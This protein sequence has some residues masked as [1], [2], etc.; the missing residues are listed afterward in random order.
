MIVRTTG[1]IRD[2]VDLKIRIMLEDLGIDNSNGTTLAQS[3]I[4]KLAKSVYGD[5]KPYF[6]IEGVIWINTS[7]INGLLNE[8]AI[9]NDSNLPKLCSIMV[10]EMLHI[11]CIGQHPNSNFGWGS[12]KLGL[13]TDMTSKNGGWLYTGKA[14]S[15][16][17]NFYKHIYCNNDKVIGIPIEDDDG[18]LGHFEEGYDNQGNFGIRNIDGVEYYPMPFEIMSTYHTDISFTSPITIGVLEDYGYEIDWNN[19]EINKAINIQVE[20]ANSLNGKSLGKAV[21][22]YFS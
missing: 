7:A 10:H 6:P 11:L 20:R 19:E 9:L 3:I 18:F 12:Q 17:I 13:V 4:L 16:A 2:G 21:S 15:K 22:E 8:R 1:Y 5:D 14:D